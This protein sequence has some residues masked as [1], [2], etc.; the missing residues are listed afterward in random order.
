LLERALDRLQRETRAVCEE[1]L[2]H[3]ATFL[4]GNLRFDIFPESRFGRRYVTQAH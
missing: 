3:H 1:G 4:H 2:E